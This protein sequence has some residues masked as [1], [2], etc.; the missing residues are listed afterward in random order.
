MLF[1]S[2]ERLEAE[3]LY[4]FNISKES[5]KMRFLINLSKLTLNKN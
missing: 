5:D 1:N 4:Y 2:I 3:R